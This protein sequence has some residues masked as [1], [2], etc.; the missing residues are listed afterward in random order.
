MYLYARWFLIAAA[1]GKRWPLFASR[2][3]GG[4]PWKTS[5]D[6]M[7]SLTGDNSHLIQNL[8]NSDIISGGAGYHPTTLGMILPILSTFKPH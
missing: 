2:S 5:K 1:S 8:Y 4:S 3:D 7:K 6:F